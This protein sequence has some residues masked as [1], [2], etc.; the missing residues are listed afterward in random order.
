MIIGTTTTTGSINLGTISTMTGGINLNSNVNI[1]SSLV[2]KSISCNSFQTFNNSDSMIIGTTTTT[3]SINLGT[4]STMTGGINLNSNVNIGSSIVN[5]SIS[6]NSFQTFN[7]SDLMRFGT[8]T[9]TGALRICENLTTGSVAIGSSTSESTTT[10]GGLIKQTRTI[11]S[12]GYSNYFNVAIGSAGNIFK[13]AN[14]ASRMPNVYNSA[15]TDQWNIWEGDAQGESCFIAQNGNTTVI[16]NPGDNSALH[17]QDE[18]S[19]GIS[20]VSGFSISVAGV[21]TSTSDSRS[22]DNIVVKDKTNILDKLQQIDIVTYTKSRRDGI[23]RSGADFKYSKVHT[24]YTAQQLI[25]IGFEEF[26]LIP[27]DPNELMS[28]C[29]GDVQFAFNQGVQELIKENEDRQMQIDALTTRLDAL[30]QRIV[31]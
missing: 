13:G 8:T 16:C 26:V 10:I 1:G 22:K 19:I 2:N 17:W 3:G 18:D 5:K 24:G 31:T 11:S 29:Y 15:S 21:I 7:N 27:D 28:V 14:S 12:I 9:T 25:E 20:E 23:E 30:E 6:C 4:I